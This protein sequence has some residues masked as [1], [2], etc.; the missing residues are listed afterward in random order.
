M[1]KLDR[2]QVQQSAL[3]HRFG[4]NLKV[5]DSD[6]YHLDFMDPTCGWKSRLRLPGVGPQGPLW[7]RPH[8]H[9]SYQLISRLDRR[10]SRGVKVGGASGLTF[11]SKS[12]G[13]PPHTRLSGRRWACFPAVVFF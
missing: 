6:F 11:Q 4:P 5:L 3:F 8:V 2:D 12:A 13:A 1:W 9:L 7:L 10:V